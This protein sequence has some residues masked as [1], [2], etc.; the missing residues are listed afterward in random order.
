[1]GRVRRSVPRSRVP[2]HRLV[3]ANP[4]LVRRWL[5]A[6]T[7]CAVTG[8]VVGRSITAAETTRSRWGTTVP[9]L[10]ADAPVERGDVLTQRVS[11]QEWPAAMVPPNA[12]VEL[13]PDATAASDLD[14][15]VPLTAVAVELS[16]A[17]P[18]ER[19][20]VAVPLGPA[21]MT[22]VAGQQ[23]DLWSTTDRTLA[24]GPSARVVTEK[25][26]T[27]AIVAVDSGAQ[28]VVV[29]VTSEEAASVVES[30]VS[31]TVTPVVVG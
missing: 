26:A 25:V 31:A 10:V 28:H 23:V 14:A 15:G 22:F 18:V 1:M 17:D 21:S 2:L 4:A 20:E 24:V 29:A 9:V 30:L 12:V 13:D 16:G 19:I 3:R 6:A 11:M 7:L 5:T 8:L 27:R